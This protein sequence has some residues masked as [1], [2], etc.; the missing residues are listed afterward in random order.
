MSDSL[1]REINDLL[2]SVM[3]FL[4]ASSVCEDAGLLANKTDCRA[5]DGLEGGGEA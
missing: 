3:K 2:T 5:V 1:A 4:T